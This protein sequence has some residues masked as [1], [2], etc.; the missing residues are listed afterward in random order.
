M[1][2]DFHLSEHAARTRAMWNADAPNWAE[3]GR[4]LWRT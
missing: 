3:S 2:D 4:A 1:A